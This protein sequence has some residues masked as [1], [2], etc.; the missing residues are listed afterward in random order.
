MID[1]KGEYRTLK[2]LLVSLGP[3]VQSS[4]RIYTGLN[5]T[6]PFSYAF[7]IGD[8][9]QNIKKMKTRLLIHKRFLGKRI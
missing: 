9:F 5:F 1:F 2:I 4:V 6:P 3:V 8:L 7:L